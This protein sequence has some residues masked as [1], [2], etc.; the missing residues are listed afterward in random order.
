M[1]WKVDILLL[2]N[3]YVGTIFAGK[4]RGIVLDASTW[5]SYIEI[6]ITCVQEYPRWLIERG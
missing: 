2:R 3:A 5:L 4:N 6:R 1:V